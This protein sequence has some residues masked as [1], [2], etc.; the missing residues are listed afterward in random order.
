MA[1]ILSVIAGKNK[2]T[3]NHNH[4]VPVVL[5]DKHN[6]LIPDYEVHD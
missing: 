3:K 2:R 4:N 5:V 6:V 1:A